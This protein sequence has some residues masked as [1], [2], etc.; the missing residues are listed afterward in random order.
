TNLANPTR[1]VF[2]D[3]SSVVTGATPQKQQGFSSI[4][5]HPGF[6]TNGYFY[7]AYVLIQRTATGNGYYDRVARFQVSTTNPNQ[8]RRD[9]EVVL[10]DQYD[11]NEAHNIN[12]LRFGPDGYLYVS[13]G[14]EGDPAD[15]LNNSQRLDKD[16]FSGILR[17]DVDMKPGN[18]LPNP[19]PSITTNYWVPA[20]NP[21]VGITSFNGVAI[22]PTQLRT[23]FYAV[24]LR[25]PWRM[26]FDP[27]TGFLY[28]GDVGESS[29]E[30]VNVIAKGGNYG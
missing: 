25:N 10:I 28:C 29:Y 30:E 9:S 20:D 14:D 22:D 17:L 7:V 4:V 5:F 6:A 15:Y 16:F 1:T 3:L 11:E 27:E 24:G 18:L 13:I 23:E 2:L 19:H 26:A 12:D 8:A 21:F